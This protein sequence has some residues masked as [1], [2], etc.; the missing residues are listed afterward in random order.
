VSNVIYLPQPKK[1]QPPAC[2]RCN[3]P[4]PAH[5]RADRDSAKQVLRG[6]QLLLYVDCPE[7]GAS[8]YWVIEFAL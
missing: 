5:V 2:P 6:K 3:W 8:L 1:N 4:M 7:C